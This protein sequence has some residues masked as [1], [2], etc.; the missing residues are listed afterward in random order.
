MDEAQIQRIM[1]HPEFQ[2]MAK[3]KNKSRSYFYHYH[4]S[5]LVRL[6]ATRGI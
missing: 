5:F 4:A 2:S 3:K 6:S 1:N